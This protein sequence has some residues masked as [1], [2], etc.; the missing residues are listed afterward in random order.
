MTDWSSIPPDQ[1]LPNVPDGYRE[2]QG[3]MINAMI[4]RI[5]SGGSSYAPNTLTEFGAKQDSTTNDTV[6]IQ[7]AFDTHPPGP[8]LGTGTPA[9]TKAELILSASGFVLRDLYLLPVF[10]DANAVLQLGDPTPAATTTLNAGASSGDVSLTLTDTTGF[11]VGE[12]IEVTFDQPA[13]VLQDNGANTYPFIT[14]IESLSSPTVTLTDSMPRGI[15]ANAAVTS[16]TRSGTVLTVTTTAA[17]GIPVGG[18]T[19]SNGR[20]PFVILKGANESQFNGTFQ[21]A[22]VPST[23]TFTI[24]VANSGSTSATGT[25][26]WSWKNTVQ[27]FLG[28]LKNAQI[29]VVI[30]ASGKNPSSPISAITQANGPLVTTSTPHGFVNGQQVTIIGPIS[31]MSQIHGAVGTVASAT[32]LTFVLSGV[33]ASGYDAYTGGA[34]AAVYNGNIVTGLIDNCDL[35]ITVK[36]ASGGGLYLSGAYGSRIR[37]RTV[38]CGN[39]NVADVMALAYT[40]CQWDIIS[41]E[42]PGFGPTLGGGHYSRVGVTGASRAATGR[43]FKTARSRFCTFGPGSSTNTG[44]T[45]LAVTWVTSDCTF[46]GFQAVG[47]TRPSTQNGGLWLSGCF[48]TD[49]NFFGINALSNTNVDLQINDTDTGNQLFGCRYSLAKAFISGSAIG[50]TTFVDSQQVTLY[51]NQILKLQ[52]T[53]FGFPLHI[54]ARTGAH[55]VDVG[56]DSGELSVFTDREA[57]QVGRGAPGSN[58]TS[59]SL[60]TTND[61]GVTTLRLVTLGAPSGGVQP[62]VVSET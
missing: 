1:P 36:N 48:N 10:T 25:L 39:D 13:W 24:T 18:P 26:L 16:I 9:L 4:D 41:E 35:D 43:G 42:P 33:D 12:L 19:S 20:Y 7:L 14:R 56:S 57:M 50:T 51:G 46:F 45:G 40:Q 52:D 6:A 58:Q 5:N 32:S 29:S 8:M 15:L 59:M 23:T 47:S 61:M 60:C 44:F 21:L 55:A 54:I 2:F 27:C 22:S 11:V 28:A 37:I 34:S 62:L 38:N 31:G 53:Q 17:H 3:E 30:D 49:N